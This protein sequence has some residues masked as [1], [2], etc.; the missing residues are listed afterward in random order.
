MPGER[1]IASVELFANGVSKSIATEAPFWPAWNT[2]QDSNGIYTVTVRACDVSGLCAEN[3]RRFAVRNPDA[4]WV[5]IRSP[6]PGATV[7]STVKVSEEISGPV[8]NVQLFVDGV[9]T[10]ESA[11]AL[12]WNAD[13]APPGFHS[14]TV[15][16]TAP[17]G[18]SGVA[19]ITVYVPAR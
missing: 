5:T 16:A 3:S 12:E 10:A 13:E 18:R 11:G 2:S 19:S 6:K 15:F 14:L 7:S 17:E 9:F 4:P 8:E 1:G